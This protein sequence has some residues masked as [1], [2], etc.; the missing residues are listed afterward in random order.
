MHVSSR[1]NLL[2]RTVTTVAGDAAAG[3]ALAS[4]CLW[5]IEA[6]ALGVF[7]TFMTWLVA[8]LLSLAL[9]Q[10]VVHPVVQ[11]VLSDRKLDDALDA[12]RGLTDTVQLR[13][14]EWRTR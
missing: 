12:L 1:R 4:A 5:L 9:S 7:L 11:R 10:Y 2:I 6:A 8:M 13:V 3:L 14:R